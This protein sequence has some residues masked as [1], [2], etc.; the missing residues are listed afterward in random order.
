MSERL[1][2]GLP[3]PM[4]FLSKLLIEVR[5]PDPGQDPSELDDFAWV[6]TTAVNPWLEGWERL[7]NA[8]YVEMKLLRDSTDIMREPDIH[9]V[10]FTQKGHAYAIEQLE[11]DQVK[12]VQHQEAVVAVSG[13]YAGQPLYGAF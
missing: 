1:Q 8:G 5:T 7:R 4:D 2:R 11:G 13:H 10:R 6:D 9:A 3:L 12:T